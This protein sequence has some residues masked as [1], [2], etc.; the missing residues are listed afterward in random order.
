MKICIHT[1]YY[2]PEI[3]APQARL[4]E[5]AKFLNKNDNEVTILTSLPNYPTGKI[6]DGYPNFFKE[7]RI[8]GIKVIRSFIYP[9]KSKKIVPRLL[10]YFSFVISSLI[11]GIIKISKQDI[12]LT[13]SPPLFLGFSG[14]V[15]SKIKGAK[16]IFNVSDL[17]PE[18]A[19]FLGIIKNGFVLNISK[20]LEEFFYKNSWLI[21]GQS[22]E[23][24]NNIKQRFPYLNVYRYSNA[25]DTDKYN[26]ANAGTFFNQFKMKK[27]I[28]IVYAGLH[29]MAQGLEQVIDC[30]KYLETSYFSKCHIFFI[31]DGPEKEFLINKSNEI[32]NCPISFIHPQPKVTMPQIWAS[33]DIA[34]I[35]LK[36]YIPGAVPSKLYEAMSSGVPIIMI[37]S[38]ESKKIVN[39]S[40]CGITVN[41][42]DLKGVSDSISR[43]IFD[44]DLREK[45]GSNGR[46]YVKTHFRR[47]I[48]NKEFLEY[49]EKN[50]N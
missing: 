25:V 11:I 7:E 2:L 38:G 4:S 39:E 15:L 49:L 34:I 17:W 22:R 8:D 3:G 16:W 31:G 21:M 10:S 29:G 45:M 42:G 30:L 40:E 12:I 14:F 9:S 33:S 32:V 18:S 20:K 41:P 35:P 50:D 36:K 5:L 23:I 6:F 28:K 47:S 37:S 43:L 27:K 26:P 46:K 19:V 1:Q 13:E 44:K 24:V 48:I